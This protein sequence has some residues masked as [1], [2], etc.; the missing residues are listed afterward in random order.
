MIVLDTNVA[1]AYLVSGD[2]F[3]DWNADN[4]VVSTITEAELFR[5]GGMGPIE[6][7]RIEQFVAACIVV[8]V[9]SAIARRAADI[10]RTRRN[11]LPDLII[12][13][14]AMEMGGTLWTRNVRDFRN[15]PGLLLK[16]V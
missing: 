15:I 6:I 13:A 16:K 2:P 9:D 3:I 7:R 12:A 1:I 5:L 10:G 14:S 8:S 11:K 4:F